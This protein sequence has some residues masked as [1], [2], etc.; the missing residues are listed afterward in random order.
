ML[1]VIKRGDMRVVGYEDHV[2]SSQRAFLLIRI[3]YHPNRLVRDIL[4]V[5]DLRFEPIFGHVGEDVD[6]G[7][8][9]YLEIG[10]ALRVDRLC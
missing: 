4:K 2:G 7:K 8:V 9:D 5:S 6:A 1:R 10:H 3:E